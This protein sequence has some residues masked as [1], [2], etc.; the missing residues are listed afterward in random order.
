MTPFF[1]KLKWLAQRRRKENE[2]S[3]ELRFHLEEEAAERHADGV[4]EDQARRAALRDLGNLT[5]LQENTRAT[6]TWMYLEQLLQDCRYALRTMG[7]NKTF[8]TLAILSLALG[9]GANT[10]IYTFMDAIL[11]RSLPVVNPDS[12][13]VVNWHTKI[14]AGGTVIHGASGNSYSDP[15]TG[16]TAG[17]FPSRHSS[18]CMS[19]APS[20]PAYSR[21]TQRAP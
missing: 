19:P 1:R 3:E 21:I 13:V 12:L 6:W 5:L 17:I 8:S 9:I 4:A 18:F 10:A 11:L 2:L 15:K 20:L 7:A 14:Q 16:T